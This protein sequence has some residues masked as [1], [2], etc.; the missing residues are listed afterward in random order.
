[1]N[2]LDTQE[3]ALNNAWEYMVLERGIKRERENCG[4]LSELR[5]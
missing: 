4:V 5:N 3:K 1:M 2:M